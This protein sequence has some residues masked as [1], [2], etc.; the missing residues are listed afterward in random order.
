MKC[1]GLRYK[2][3]DY[4]VFLT[5]PMKTPKLRARAPSPLT[6]TNERLLLQL[7]PDNT[8]LPRAPGSNTRIH[9][10]SKSARPAPHLYPP[11]PPNQHIEELNWPMIGRYDCAVSD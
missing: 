10:V 11:P 4:V 6:A 9:D 8:S 5:F 7:L 3:A 1:V 2:V